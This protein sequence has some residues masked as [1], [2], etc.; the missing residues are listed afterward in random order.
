M[1]E[2]D[3]EDEALAVA[4]ERYL[5]DQTLHFIKT[6]KNVPS[7]DIAAALRCDRVLIP[8]EILHYAAGLLDGSPKRRGKPID[9]NLESAK[10]AFSDRNFLAEEIKAKYD[11]MKKDGLGKYEIFGRIAEEYGKSEDWVSSKLYPRNR[12][13]DK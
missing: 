12:E 8:K 5:I 1:T 11:A 10:E 6:G 2:Y 4:S 3:A 7:K 9:V 13:I